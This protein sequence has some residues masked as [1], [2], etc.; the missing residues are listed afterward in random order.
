MLD[1]HEYTGSYASNPKLLVSSV[2]PTLSYS[3]GSRA[4]SEPEVNPGH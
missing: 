1:T 4:S 3:S 2:I